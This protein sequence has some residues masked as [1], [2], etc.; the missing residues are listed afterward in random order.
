M[1][2]MRIAAAI[3]ASLFI[4]SAQAQTLKSGHVLGNGTGS[5]RTATDTPLLSIMRQPGSGMGSGVGDALAQG[6]PTRYL[7]F[8]ALSAAAAPI[9]GTVAQTS[10]YATSGDGGAADYVFCAGC[11]NTVNGP[12]VFVPGSGSGRWF[13]Q[14]PATGVHPEAA[15]AVCNY[16]WS[17]FTG[18]DDTAALNNLSGYIQ[19]NAAGS[20]EIVWNPGKTCLV[21]SASVT[22]RRGVKFIGVGQPMTANGGNPQAFVPSIALNPSYSMICGPSS[23]IENMVIMRAGLAMKPATN[24]AAY[25]YQTSTIT[26]G[27]IAINN[28]GSDCAIKN[29]MTIGF[30]QGVYSSGG[31]RLLVED[32]YC[33]T[34][35]CL[36]VTANA[37]TSFIHRVRGYPFWTFNFNNHISIYSATVTAVGS[38]F[39]GSPTM[40]IPGGTCATQPTATAT[41]SGGGIA[42][43]AMLD[44]GDC[45]VSP[46][47]WG[48]SATPTIRLGGS[49]YAASATFNVTLAGGSPTTASVVSVSTNSSGVVTTVN[50]VTTVGAY[51]ISGQPNPWNSPTGGAGTGLQLATVMGKNALTLTGGAGSGAK[52]TI[53][54]IDAS[55]RP[56]NCLWLHDQFDGG[57]VDGSECQGYQTQAVLS[58]IWNDELDYIGGEGGANN[59][60]KGTIGIQ[61]QNCV[62]DVTIVKPNS[63]VN[64]YGLYFAHESAANGGSCGGATNQGANVTVLGGHIGF[65]A[66]TTTSAILL[67]AKSTGIIDGVMLGWPNA[68]LGWPVAVQVQNNAGLWQ[69]PSIQFDFSN[70]A[71]IAQWMNVGSGA[72]TPVIG[73]PY[74]KTLSGDGVTDN[75]AALQALC[76]IGGDQQIPAGNFVVNVPSG[77]AICAPAANTTFHGSGAGIS[78]ITY[79]VADTTYVNIYNINANKIT[80]K[81]LT[82]KIIMPTGGTAVLYNMQ[83]S[84]ILNLLDGEIS[85]NCVEGL[86]IGGTATNTDVLHVAFLRNGTTTTI[87]STVTTGQTAAQMAAALAA[88]INA[89]STVIGW[90]VVATASGAFV[91]IAEPDALT[92]Q[93]SY[94]LSVT[95]AATETLTA[96]FSS[97][98]VVFT[99]QTNGAEA[100]DVLEQNVYLHDLTWHMLKTNASTQT[101]RRWRFVND[102]CN[103]VFDGCLNMNS[104]IAIFD[105]VDING[106]SIG[107]VS[108][109]A[110]DGLPIAC[111]GISNMTVRGV[112]MTGTYNQNAFH[113]E[114]GCNA[115]IYR[116]DIANV[117]TSGNAGPA[118]SGTCLFVTDNNIGGTSL[119]SN[120]IVFDI[121]CRKLDTNAQG[122]GV[123]FSI[124]TTATTRISVPNLLVTGWP[125]CLFNQGAVEFNFGTLECNNTGSS[126]GTTAVVNQQALGLIGAIQAN[127]YATVLTN[128]GGAP[129]AAS[130]TGTSC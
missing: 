107:A 11:S 28:N 71:V 32:L 67:A 63:D 51:P 14:V 23:A 77:T 84:D 36:Q 101:N 41:L 105:D 125:Q 118:Y 70:P 96:G 22:A 129:R 56:G 25:A 127:N 100:D 115:G 108:L 81:G 16:N 60:D 7:N 112:R 48:L 3:I 6:V 26:D 64:Q 46:Q 8:S 31:A 124:I 78:N 24:E 90:G 113:L 83:N 104:P 40:T 114:Q 35:N 45:T 27:S 117:A 2:I 109:N 65:N 130:C 94:T 57:K 17:T 49:G 59:Y 98:S 4:L 110:P 80:F 62:S 61:T 52:A 9:D 39:T 72:V 92:P 34:A 126:S 37:D 21:N 86:T 76:S 74:G 15:G 53:S 79:N 55:Y 20:G 42:S 50:S 95:G 68:A 10:G 82:Q 75:F 29:V 43:L 73:A 97:V 85:S 30:N 122:Y 102:R 54:T 103:R 47:T 89:N 87:N 88:A 19:N 44:T 13:L 99:N 93:A 120:D 121:T 106:L 119:G 12:F 38:G 1:K 66:G 18:T 69:F 91:G 111:S 5:E 123:F 33:D 128:T 58:N 116:D